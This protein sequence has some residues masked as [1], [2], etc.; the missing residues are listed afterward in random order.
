MKIKKLLAA[1][2][3]C[4]VIFSSLSLAMAAEPLSF[5][6]TVNDLNGATQVK[7]YRVVSIDETNG[8][9]TYN[10]NQK[11]QDIFDELGVDTVAGLE[12]QQVKDILDA[13]EANIT[14]V[15]PAADRTETIAASQESFTLTGIDM[16]YYYITMAGADGTIYNPMLVMVPEQ[17][18]AGYKDT[19]VTAKTHRPTIDKEIKE[20]TS[21]GSKADADV[22][23]I[24]D[25][26][27]TVDVPV[28]AD[29]VDPADVVFRLT[30]KMSTG[31][32]WV[33]EQAASV[34]DGEGSPVTGALK[35]GGPSSSKG[36]D[37]TTVTFDFDYEK[38][39][40]ESSIIVSYKAVVNKDAVTGVPGNNNSVDLTY[41]D[42]PKTGGTFTT[43]PDNTTLYT[44]GLNVTKAGLG[45]ADIVLAGAEF[46]LTKGG[47]KYYFVKNGNIY[48]AFS[49]EAYSFTAAGDTFS[50][51]PKAGYESLE[52]VTGAVDTVVSG[53]DG[54]I[55]ING[56]DA[57]TYTLTETKAPEDYYI[58]SDT[59]EFTVA[60]E[61]IADNQDG[62][63]GSVAKSSGNE[64]TAAAD[65]Y[66]YK[67]IF[68][69][70]QYVLPKTGD[71]GVKI[72]IG[73]G[74][75]MIAAACVMLWA[76]RKK[77]ENQE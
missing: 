18:G 7:L 77:N 45:N 32:T 10:I 55:V 37:G 54:K 11:Y 35:A 21:W 20:G 24:V 61:K 63:T 51:T 36:V 46:T 33:E 75:V 70:T 25:F 74:A 13:L 40:D 49:E 16:G 65:A 2:L 39:K 27:V 30:D 5:D 26:R 23:D 73:C 50:G 59:V 28:Y 14:D 22:G 8:T 42:D 57:G 66:Y 53:S 69:S 17:D 4:M 43:T 48:T 58:V 3:S 44:Y 56:L 31:L 68:N 15:S 47:S 67:T 6:L 9:L 60:A 76:R 38:I 29:N 64:N 12:T 62:L 71:M 19:V 41:T 72:I 52:T 34:T 1:L